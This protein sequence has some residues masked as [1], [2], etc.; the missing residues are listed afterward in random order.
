MARKIL[1]ACFRRKYI[2]AEGHIGSELFAFVTAM[3]QRG[4]PGRSQGK[5]YPP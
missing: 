3:K 5:I 2:M 4:I 1:F